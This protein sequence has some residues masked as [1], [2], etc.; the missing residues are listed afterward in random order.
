MPWS[1]TPTFTGG[2]HPLA[3]KDRLVAAAGMGFEIKPLTPAMTGD[4]RRLNAFMEEVAVRLGQPVRP[5]SASTLE[6]RAGLHRSL[7][8]PADLW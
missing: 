3:D 8:T 7:F 5:L 4:Q 2:D 6:R 1:T